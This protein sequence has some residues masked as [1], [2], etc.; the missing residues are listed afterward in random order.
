MSKETIRTKPILTRVLA[1]ALALPLIFTVAAC[2]QAGSNNTGAPS[3]APAAESETLAQVRV[4]KPSAV[5][6]YY[7]AD[8][9]GFFEEEGI[10][11]VPI[12]L[13][14]GVSVQQAAEQDIIDYMTGG[15]VTGFA[16]ARIAGIQATATHPGMVDNDKLFHI[17][18][19]AKPDSLLQSLD[20]LGS[21]NPNSSDGKWTF[22]VGGSDTCITG[23]PI[24]Y[25]NS[26][27]LDTQ[28]VQFTELEE[29]VILQAIVAGQLDLGAVHSQRQPEA[30]LLI[31]DG[32]LARIMSSWEM[33]GDEYAGL[34]VRGFLQSFIDEHRED[35][36]IQA[37]SNAHYKARVW[38][39]EEENR[40][41]AILWAV[42]DFGIDPTKVAFQKFTEDTDINEAA[43]ERWFEIAYLA[44][45]FSPED[46]VKPADT[47]TNE[48]A[49][50]VS[51]S[52]DSIRARRPE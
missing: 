31:A 21:P 32:A 41:L 50:K 23:Y 37:F 22:G 24:Y 9:L 16:R 12:Q 8:K 46:P 48:F 29:A 4:P 45:E 38:L 43:I 5:N 39:N 47:Y 6:E 10:Q 7:V 2:G 51:E 28:Y 49:A 33:F 35:G 14:D 44:G 52:K 30:D 17:A 18:Y 25:L 19:Y 27:N 1:A 11:I 13:G 36:V 26:R 15:H 34:S 42:E 3:A 40:Q 20:D